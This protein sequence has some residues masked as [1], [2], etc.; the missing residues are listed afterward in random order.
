MADSA[1]LD[2][3]YGNASSADRFAGVESRPTLVAALRTVQ[4]TQN[5][6]SAMADTK[7]SI[8]ITICSIVLTIGL[9][10]FESPILR[11]PLVILTGSVSFAL[12]FAVLSVLPS[13]GAPR[14]PNGE[15]DVDAPWF[16]LFFFGHFAELPR[17]RFESMLAEVARDDARIY[18]MIARDIYGQG[19][20]LAHK[21]YR[22]LRL[23]YL[24][25]L[26]GLFLTFLGAL[27]PTFFGS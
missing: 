21:K 6:L 7:A 8:M 18:A 4:Q 14:T 9:T 17:E 27:A 15:L 24:T 10:R 12:L 2:D 26:C 11:W 25:F 20:V 3:D 23:S 1:W 22:L 16:N 19:F 13:V 5:Q